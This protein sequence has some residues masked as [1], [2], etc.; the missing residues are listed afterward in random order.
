[1]CHPIGYRVGVSVQIAVRLPDD[2]VAEVDSIVAVGAEPS[3]ATII[4]VA[5]R[6]ELRRR[7]WE[8]EVVLLTEQGDAYADL[9]GLHEY[10]GRS[11]HSLD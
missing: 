4:E 3:R 9:N 8:Q 10:V 6:R 2:L 5:L 1:M 7:I 11:D